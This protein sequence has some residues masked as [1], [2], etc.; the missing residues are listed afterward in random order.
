MMEA[1]IVVKWWLI[2]RLH[3]RVRN[4]FVSDGSAPG[5]FSSV[6]RPNNYIYRP[7][8]KLRKGNGFTP[9]YQSFCSRGGGSAQVHAWIHNHHHLRGQTLP[10]QT[11]TWEDTIWVDTPTP[12]QTPPW[13]ETP[14]GRHP[15]IR[16]LLLECILVASFFCNTQSWQ[17]SH[18]C[19]V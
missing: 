9:V 17:C 13:T 1:L 14:L 11:H 12:G 18:F 5:F 7:Q 8:T 15:S 3:D 2:H 6:V 10:R 19:I 16:R 4:P